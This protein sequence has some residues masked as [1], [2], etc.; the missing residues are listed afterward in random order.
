MAKVVAL[1]GA[2]GSGKSTLLKGL[3]GLA[4]N[5]WSLDSFRVS[6]AVQEQLGWTTLDNVTSSWATMTEFQEEVYRQKRDRDLGIRRFGSQWLV[7]T[8]RS[9]ADI[10]AYTTHWTW[11]LVDQGKIDVREA[12]PWLSDYLRRCAEAQIACYDAIL[13]LP[14]MRNVLWESD[15]NRAKRESAETIYEDVERFTQKAVFLTQ[16]K[17]TITA[18]SVEDRIAQV[19]TFLRTV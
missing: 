5:A 15:P 6:R 1:S 12:S 16:K 11:I 10:A 18:A 13:L 3:N 2:Q 9:F 14:L 17:F 4:E 7:L 8:E 19:D